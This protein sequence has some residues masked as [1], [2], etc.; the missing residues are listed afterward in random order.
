MFVNKQTK[1]NFVKKTYKQKQ[2]NRANA[3]APALSTQRI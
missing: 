2:A 3:Q 1:Y